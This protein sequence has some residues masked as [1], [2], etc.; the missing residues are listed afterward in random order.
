METTA[1][2]QTALYCMTIFHALFWLSRSNFNFNLIIADGILTYDEEECCCCLLAQL[3][4]RRKSNWRLHDD[5]DEKK[6][7]KKN[8][9]G[10]FHLLNSRRIGFCWCMYGEVSDQVGKT[11]EVRMDDEFEFG[12][13]EEPLGWILRDATSTKWSESL[14]IS[15][16]VK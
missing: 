7:I 11:L 14:N 15:V 1:A 13:L 2:A 6:N 5:Q 8:S 12:A 16:A 10:S 9:Q 4:G 3:N